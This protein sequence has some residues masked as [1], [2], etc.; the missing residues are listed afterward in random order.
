MG[1]PARSAREARW[2][3]ITLLRSPRCC[4]R[5]RASLKQ[6]KAL[7]AARA[8]CPSA[9]GLDFKAFERAKSPPLTADAS[10]VCNVD[11]TDALQQQSQALGASAGCP[12][13]SSKLTFTPWHPRKLELRSEKW[14][15]G[16]GRD[17]Q[18]TPNAREPVAA[19]SVVSC[20]S[21]LTTWQ[22]K[23]CVAAQHKPS[24]PSDWPPA[25][26]DAQRS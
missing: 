24:P 8:A 9:K 14:A 16:P 11:H 5:Y 18:R 23:R 20:S 4:W 6:L 19:I 22:R 3:K 15:R 12:D 17:V 7:I 1:A 2:C 13:L 21:L 10:A 26:V 25:Q